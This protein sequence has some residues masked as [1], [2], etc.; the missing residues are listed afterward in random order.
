VKIKKGNKPWGFICALPTLVL[1]VFFVFKIA[2]AEEV[3]LSKGDVIINEL[4][5]AGSEI[6]TADEF[7]ELKN[8]TNKFTDISG[9]KIVNY[10]GDVLTIPNNKIISPDGYFLISNYDEKNSIINVKPDFVSTGVSLSNDHLKISL[11]KGDITLEDNLMDVAG[12]EKIPLAGDKGSIKKSM[13]RNSEIKDGQL[14]TSWH[15]CFEAA[16]LDDDDKECATPSAN[17]SIEKS[18]DDEDSGK[19]DTNLTSSSIRINEILPFPVS[20]EEF[21]EIYN[22]GNISVDLKGWILHDASKAGKFEFLQSEIINAK[23]YLVVWKNKFKFALNNSGDESLSLFDPL[24]NL[25][26]QV[27]FKGSKKGL[28]YSFDGLDWHWSK[29]ITAGKEN[30]F[31]NL[32]V[33]RI[34]YDKDIYADVYANFQTHSK[35]ANSD[36]LKV[37]WEFGD[38]H[39]AYKAKTRHKYDKEGIYQASL[40][41]SDDSEETIE[42]FTIEVKDFPERKIKIIAINANPKGKDSE[43]ETITIKNESRK[44]LNLKGWSIMTGKTN[45]PITEDF[46]LKK[47]EIKEITREISKFTLNNKKSEIRLKYP[48]GDTADKVKYDHGKTSIAED[49]KYVKDGK[50][51]KWVEKL[52]T[53]RQQL[54]ENTTVKEDGVAIDQQPLEKNKFSGDKQTGENNKE[55]IIETP[56]EKVNSESM[57]IKELMILPIEEKVLGTEVVRNIDGNYS[58]TKESEKSEHYLLTFMK[59]LSANLNLQLNLV[60]NSYFK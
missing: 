28:S 33:S 55:I 13:E 27:Y 23:D 3:N 40:K 21:I 45:H 30:I 51:W 38:G 26:S 34:E 35:D 37:I 7:I 56:A 47:K 10:S 24:A 48:D 58:F 8:T 16:N 5:W 59:K 53:D 9:W 57:I 60:L 32:P 42:N 15:T 12:D 2:A 6:S 43:G 50:K 19:S 44:K 25:I 29:F 54:I 18:N 52:T 31:N 1:A 36:K 20:G 11:Y 46:V 4:M 49:E 39:K 14:K 41:I 22:S 17:N